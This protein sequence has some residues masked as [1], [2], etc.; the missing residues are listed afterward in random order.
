MMAEVSTET[1]MPDSLAPMLAVQSPELP[2]GEGWG[3]EIKWDGIRAIAFVSGGR[4]RLQGR[5]LV[6]VTV[7]Y[8]ELAPLGPAL[9]PHEIVADGE[10]VAMAVD[11][12]P[13]FGRLQRRMHVRD[14][15]SA[16]RLAGQVPVTYV[17]FDLLHL[18]GRDTMPLPYRERRALLAELDLRGPS[19]QA[20]R[21]HVGDGAEMAQ[22][23]RAR[24]LE[25]L[26]AK[27]LDS[28]YRPGRR[29]PDW[30]KHKNVLRQELVIGGWLPGQG[31]RSG[32][33]GALLVGYHREGG[34]RYAGRVG[35]GFSMEELDRLG[36]L[37]ASRQ[38]DRSPFV[39]PPPL[40]Q[41]V[42]RQ[43][44]FVEPDLVAEVGFGEWTH[45]GTVRHPR[46]LG[47]RPD[48]EAGEVVR[49]T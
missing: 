11:G 29:T 21:H 47:L 14:A 43:A 4:L 45:T 16:L 46:Y 22:A 39:S 5:R 28:P 24:G 44:R 23:A 49:E 40:P 30:R 12:R 2:L 25:G 48:R 34:L 3:Y 26:M 38:R 17:V 36:A 8:P 15:G 9:A 6:D 33:V 19:W 10:V 1:P 32:R 37:L 18:D 20:P 13:D 27:R 7:A 35:T 31:G 42:A 41:P